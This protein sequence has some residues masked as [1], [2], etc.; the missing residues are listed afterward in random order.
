MTTRLLESGIWAAGIVLAG[1]VLGCQ[2]ASIRTA[3]RSV[4]VRGSAEAPVVADLAT[5][6]LNV[7]ASGNDLAEVQKQLS[8]DLAKIR[9]FLTKHG[10]AE[11]D[12]EMASLSVSDARANQY[13]NNTGG[14]RYVVS[15][16]VSVRSANLD[17]IF[18]AKNSLDELLGQGVVLTSSYGPNYAF[19][20]LND[21]KLDLVSRATA[22]AYKAAEQFAK[23]SGATVGGIKRATQGSVQILGRDSY[24]S[25]SEQVNKILRVVTTV[26]YSL[27]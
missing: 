27:E 6:A 10:I 4:Q 17:G 3:D 16:G 14:D 20:K 26:D 23:D 19:T 5:W 13:N 2:I 11:A 21:A 9:A 22:E 18:K 8:G 24:L 15:G 25:E 7:S 12:V 1:Y